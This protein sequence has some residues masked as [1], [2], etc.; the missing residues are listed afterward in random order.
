MTINKK[1]DNI[2]LIENAGKL[3]GLSNEEIQKQINKVQ[4]IED[5]SILG[6]IMKEEILKEKKSNPEI[7]YSNEESLI[8]K[9]M[10]NFM[11]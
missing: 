10:N 1:S 2:K 8:I 3:K 11:H 7:F 5:M 6:T 9:K 4:L